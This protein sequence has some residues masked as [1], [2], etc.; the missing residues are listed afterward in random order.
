M[1]AVRFHVKYVLFLGDFKLE[2]SQWIF[3][4]NAQ[5]NFIKLGWFSG[6]RVVPIGR[7]G[8]QT[9][10]TK[11]ICALRNFAN[12]SRMAGATSAKVLFLIASECV[13]E[14]GYF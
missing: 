4:K 7:T 2:F 6:C 11:L 3:E 1:A 12:A 10:I 5:M 8:G 13:S 14:I 9:D